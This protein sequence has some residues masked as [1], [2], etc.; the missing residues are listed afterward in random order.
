MSSTIRKRKAERDMAK[1]RQQQIIML[2]GIIIVAVVVLLVIVLINQSPTQTPVIALDDESAYDVYQPSLSADGMPQLGSEDAPVTIY[3]YLSYGC[4]HCANF[5]S[6]QFKEILN[7][8]EDG[9]VRFVTVPVSNNFSALASAAAFCAYDQGR[10][11]EMED[12]LFGYLEQYGGNAFTRSRIMDAASALSLDEDVFS[13]CLNASA[14]Q[15]KIEGAN[16]LF[17]AL[18]DRYPNTVTGTPT[19]TFNGEPPEFGSGAAPMDYIRQRI[20]ELAG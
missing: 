11:Y 9:T 15:N 18:A 12:I 19:L 8:V 1:K 2:V 7:Y 5:H 6:D 17:F 16:A 13:D 4:G 3:E 20:D 14:T 10:F